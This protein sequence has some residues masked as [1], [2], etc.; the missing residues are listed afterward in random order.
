MNE[1]FEE[2]LFPYEKIRETQ[3]DLIRKVEEVIE[4][5]KNMIVHAPTG[6]GKTIATIGPA[7]SYAIKNNK[8]IFFLTSR[9]TQHMIVIETLKEIK[10]RF[11]TDFNTAD[12]IGKRWMCTQPG[13]DNFFSKDFNEFC[14]LLVEDN[15]CEYYKNTREKNKICAKAQKVIEDINLLDP[16]DCEELI[17]IS[18]EEKLC[19]Y[20][21]SIERSKKAKIIIADYYYIFNHNIRSSFLA[22]T[23]KKLEDSIIIIDEV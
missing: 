1:N 17:D 14:K 19:P 11:N 12:I 5:K 15:Q 21:L 10:K 6:L 18:R 8:T 7:L 4:G 20:E 22:K 9:H 2:I 16:L 3:D 23:N 13:V